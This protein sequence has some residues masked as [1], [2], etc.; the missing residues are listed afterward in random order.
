MPETTWTLTPLQKALRWSLFG[1]TL[2]VWTGVL[3]SP[4]APLAVAVVVH[5]S[6]AK[7][8][9]AKTAHVCGYAVLS[10][11]VGCLPVGRR[12]RIGWWLFLVVHGGLTEYL[13]Q[14]VPGRYPALRDVVLDTVGIMLG[15]AAL[16]AW[17][18]RRQG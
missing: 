8:W 18:R 10:I 15:L 14:F 16:W 6:T 7:F 13:Q 9:V 12:Q 3:L 1:L 4:K 17:R 5:D 11:L 2:A